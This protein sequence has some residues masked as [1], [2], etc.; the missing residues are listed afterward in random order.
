MKKGQLINLHDLKIND[1]FYMEY[2]HH[3]RIFRVKLI[4]ENDGL[5]VTNKEW[6]KETHFI[7][8]SE[9][10]KIHYLGKTNKFKN[11]LDYGNS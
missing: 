4:L 7:S 1:L 5:I 3:K 10:E 8:F 6:G 11:F 9:K 2:L